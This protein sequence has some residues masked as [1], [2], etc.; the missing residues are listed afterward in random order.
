MRAADIRHAGGVRAADTP[1]AGSDGGDDT[2]RLQQIV[3]CD[4]R[5]LVRPQLTRMDGPVSA[6]GGTN[7]N[8]PI[9]S[10]GGQHPSGTGRSDGG[11]VRPRGGR[12]LM[13]DLGSIN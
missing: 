8:S 12:R 5:R 10:G 6:S 3:S 1:A 7:Q 13:E 4:G 2:G 11:A 9:I